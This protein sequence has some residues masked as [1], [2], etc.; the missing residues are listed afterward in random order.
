M[1]SLRGMSLKLDELAE[2][3]GVSART[4]RY[5]IQRG[6]LPAPEFRGPDTAYDERHLFAL[7]AIRRL[8]EAYWPLDAIASTLAHKSVDDLRDIAEGE[9]PVLPAPKAEEVGPPKGTGAG[10]SISREPSAPRVRGQRILL[11][12]GVELWVEEGADHALV[13]ALVAFSQREVAKH[14]GEPD[15]NPPAHHTAHQTA[16]QTAHQTAHHKA[17]HTARKGKS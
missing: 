9:L 15:T 17:H 8:Q 11:A 12:R 7:R 5:Y 1:F 13:D 4:V 10:S 16:R 2:R 6:V 3:A 14:H